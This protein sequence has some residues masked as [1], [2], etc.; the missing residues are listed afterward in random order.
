LLHPTSIIIYD[1][2]VSMAQYKL[3]HILHLRAKHIEIKTSF[4]KILCSKMSFKYIIYWYWSSMGWYLYK[5]HNCWQIWIYQKESEW[6]LP[7]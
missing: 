4:Y 5:T 7:M 3:N 2:L 1:A 6:C